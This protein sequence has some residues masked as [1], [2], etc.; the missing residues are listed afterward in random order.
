M[1]S[2]LD[3]FIDIPHLSNICMLRLFEW[4]IGSGWL[5]G[6]LCFTS[7]WQQCHLETA[8]PFTVPCDGPEARFLHR[9]HQESNPG[10]SRGSPLHYRCA[11]P[12]P[13]GLEEDWKIPNA[14]RTQGPQAQQSCI[15]DFELKQVAFSKS[16]AHIYSVH[17]WNS[18]VWIGTEQR[19]SIPVLVSIHLSTLQ[20]EQTKLYRNSLFRNEPHK[21]LGLGSK[22][23]GLSDI[24]LDV[25]MS[26]TV[27]DRTNP[28]R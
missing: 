2:L 5:V 21:I 7:H 4:L 19:V 9:S 25:D 14:P 17:I 23:Y 18:T 1:V 27:L 12:A 24:F 16:P 8:P 22:R 10:P 28:K 26:G 6:W 20:T 3:G 11:T 15:C 13:L